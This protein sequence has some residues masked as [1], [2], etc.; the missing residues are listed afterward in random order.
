LIILNNRGYRDADSK[1]DGPDKTMLGE[2]QLKWLEQQLLKSDA[3]VK[4]VASSVPISVPTGKEYARDGWANG[5]NVNPN[6]PTGFENE[7]RKISDF[8]I[9]KGIKNVYFVTTDVHYA[10]IIQ[11]DANHDGKTDYRELISGPI[12]AGKSTPKSLDPTFGPERLYAE[13]DFFNFGVFRVDPA[14]NKATVEIRDES[15]KIHFSHT[16]QLEN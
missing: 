2:D 15:G 1:A 12:G 5:D 9:E 16:F 8:I 7:F 13:G 10:D 11:Y 14:S 4:L 6:D 3:K